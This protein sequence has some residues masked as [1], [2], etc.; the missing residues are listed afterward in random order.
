MPAPAASPTMGLRE[1]ALLLL[2][3]VLWGASFFFF[4]VLVAELPTMTIVLARLSLAAILLNIVVKVRREAM[5]RDARRWGQFFVMGFLN[6]ALPFVLLVWAE[7]K[8]SSG[9][10]SIL[11]ATTPVFSV[12]IAHFY[13]SNEKLNWNKGFGVLFGLIGV[14]VLIGPS[15]LVS[16]GGD[17]L[18]PEL[19]CLFT[20]LVYAIAGIYGRRFKDLPSLTVATGQVTASTLMLLPV[21]LIIDHPWSLPNPS[22]HA[23]QAIVGLAVFSTALAYIIYFRILATAGAT[24]VLLVTLLVPVSAILLGVLFL[25]ELF[26]AQT[27]A[28]MCLIA[29]GLAA[30]DGRLPAAVSAQLKRK[31][32]S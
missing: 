4:K 22:V 10:A 2:L 16:A 28:G 12:L 29:L 32:A 6:N 19:S 1:W 3:S 21:T 31:R 30:I 7:T 15:I 18:I 17:E 14:F 9:L 24:N 27:L 26:T 13:T 23:W 11:N 8:I 20:A 25:N 5:P